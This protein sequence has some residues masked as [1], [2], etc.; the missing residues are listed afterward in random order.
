M[1]RSADDTA[2][3][4]EAQGSHNT[5]S[6]CGSSPLDQ[7]H[8]PQDCPQPR[9]A[10]ITTSVPT[11]GS[12]CGRV[13]SIQHA[14]PAALSSKIPAK[15]SSS[16]FGTG[17]LTCGPRAASPGLRAASRGAS[18]WS[19]AFN[20]SDQL[21]SPGNGQA[22]PTPATEGS[23]VQSV[24]SP[25]AGWDLG[26]DQLVFVIRVGGSSS[27]YG[28]SPTSGGLLPVISPDSSFVAAAPGGYNNDHMFGTSWGHNTM[29]GQGHNSAAGEI[30]GDCT[31]RHWSLFEPQ[32]RKRPSWRL[33]RVAVFWSTCWRTHSTHAQCCSQAAVL[34]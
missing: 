14:S 3:L 26:W 8:R 33:T 30:G 12:S 34:L 1:P 7:F 10:P 24:Q 29:A 4:K 15:R 17:A 25:E 21:F 18:S 5:K 6:S 2:Q 32:I 28:S 22:R 27:Y 16:A 9:E 20:G 31:V 13:N 11:A 19:T 23:S